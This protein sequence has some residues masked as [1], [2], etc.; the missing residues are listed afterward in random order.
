M[1]RALAVVDPTKSSKD[2][3]RK[4]GAIAEAMDAELRILH[5]TSDSEYEEDRKAMEELASTDY[6][7]YDIG[8]AEAGARQFA[9]DLAADVL[10]DSDVTYEPLGRI[11]DKANAVLSTIEKYDCDHVFIAGRKRS[12]TGKAIFGDAPQRIILNADVPV[13]ITTEEE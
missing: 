7:R 2:L 5:V 1:Q 6:G 12:P 8:Q 11:G 9:S 3:L 10:G 4:A 13:T